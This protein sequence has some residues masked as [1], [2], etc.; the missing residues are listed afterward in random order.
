MQHLY[1]YR[2]VA[3]AT[4]SLFWTIVFCSCVKNLELTA[5]VTS[6]NSANVYKSDATA[7]AVL[8]G[9]YINMSQSDFRS[10]GIV[11]MSL[12]PGLSADELTLYDLNNTHYAPYYR[13]H[14]TSTNVLSSDFWLKIYPIIFTANAAI[15][16]LTNTSSLTP[17]VRRQLL[18]EAKFI[19]AFCFFQLVNLYGDIPLTITTDY[20]KNRLL[21]RAPQSQ[22]WQ[23][24]IDDLKA[25]QELLTDGYVKA[26]AVSPYPFTDTERVRPNKWAAGALLA[27]S[28]LYTG[29][30]VNAEAQASAVIANAALYGLE[31]LNNVFLKNS[32][33][34]IWQLQPVRNGFNTQDAFLFI[35]SNTGVNSDWPVYLSSSLVNSFEPGDRRKAVW[36]GIYTDTIPSPDIDYYYAHKYKAFFDDPVTEY[37]MVLRLGEL[38]LTRA[39]ARVEQNNIDGGRSDLN[40]IRSRAGLDPTSANDKATLLNVIFQ[41]RFVELFTE[42]GHRWLDLKRSKKLDAVMSVVTP[43]KGGTWQSN[44]QWYPI[45]NDELVKDP[46]L[47]QNSGY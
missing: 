7:A 35:L 14:L 24:I 42:W 17:A 1:K 8:T 10:G 6:T 20:E 25:A 32:K 47:R 39:E 38:Y 43:Q 16:G 37:T 22:V 29:D 30:W 41:E 5:P 36:T 21:P 31:P 19:R 4:S 34:A 44:W 45:P 18:G 23:Q 13:N 28:Y 9:I 40:I 33:E 27:R 2:K 11:S 46:N 15:E 12:F 26:D 3:F